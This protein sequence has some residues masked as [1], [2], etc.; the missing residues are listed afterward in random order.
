M[1]D[2]ILVPTDGSEHARRAGRHALHL[3]RAFDAAVHVIS[4]VDVQ[5]AAGLFDA[6]GVDDAFVGRLETQGQEAI[7]TVTADAHN[8]D[9]VATALVRGSPG[10]AILEYAD[11]H[12]IDLVAMGTHGR[13]G[14]DRFVAGSVTERV[15]RRAEMPVLTVRAVETTA[16]VGAYEK[17][18]IPT[19]GSG[20]AAGAIDHGLAI[21]EATGARVHA[22][23]VVDHGALAAAGSEAELP[24]TVADH[25]E[26]RAERAV[27]AIETRARDRG[28][29]VVTAVE[30]GYPAA[31]LLEYVDD[32]GID[33]VAMGT[34]GRTGVNRFLL[35]S[36]TERV[37]RHAPVPVLAVNARSADTTA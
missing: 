34:T 24:S 2:T 8:T 22:V 17:V 18:L 31:A 25:L 27:D 10:A 5:A 20:A 13:T 35:G 23:S 12:G 7:E 16:V 36:T 21:A 30:R 28:L 11:D 29:D 9:T 14:V 4:V 37:I 33:L 1:Y 3:A 15:V 19:D 6:G 32:C 26:A